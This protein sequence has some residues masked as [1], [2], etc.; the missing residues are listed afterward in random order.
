MTNWFAAELMAVNDYLSC[1]VD[2]EV[3][4]DGY[5]SHIPKDKE[6]RKQYPGY[7]DEEF[8]KLALG[9]KIRREIT[10]FKTLK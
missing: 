4:G 9:G 6:L 8:E 10:C 1:Q 3:W 7:S 5:Q 2:V